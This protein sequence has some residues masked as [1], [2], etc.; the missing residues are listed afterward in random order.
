M[1]ITVFLIYITNARIVVRA[2]TTA[3][4]SK[5]I[6]VLARPLFTRHAPAYGDRRDSAPQLSLNAPL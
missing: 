5:R 6:R 1:N 3:D 4:C 2:V